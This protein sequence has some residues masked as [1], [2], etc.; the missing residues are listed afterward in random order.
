MLFN[1]FCVRA[2]RVITPV[3]L[4]GVE[5]SIDLV[6]EVVEPAFGRAF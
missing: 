1:G 3:F 2:F 6:L 4:Q 5:D